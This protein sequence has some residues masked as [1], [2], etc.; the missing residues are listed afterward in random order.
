M[1][2]PK[3][4]GLGPIPVSKLCKHPE[5]NAYVQAAKAFSDAK[6]K[7][8]EAKTAM[9]AILK[10]GAAELRDIENLDFTWSVGA[11][12][13]SVFEQ[14]QTTSRRGLKEIAFG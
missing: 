11:K 5:W 10:K 14:L 6:D 9:K 4:R 2:E 3:T 8:Q 1:A 13:I 12:E 7:A